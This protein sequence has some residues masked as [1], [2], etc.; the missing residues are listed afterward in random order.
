[1]IRN[2][3]IKVSH[4]SGLSN[5]GVQSMDSLLNNT[6]A[7]N[8]TLTSRGSVVPDSQLS[9]NFQQSLMQQ[10][11]SPNQQRGNTPFSPQGNQSK[12]FEG[13]K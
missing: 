2:E 9:P 5:Q 1:V 7:P 11:L 6:V 3:A 12:I 13:K 4:L 10:Q 8:V